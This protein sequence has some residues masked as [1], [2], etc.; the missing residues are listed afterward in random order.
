MGGVI[1]VDTWLRPWFIAIGVFLAEHVVKVAGWARDGLDIPAI[2]DHRVRDTARNEYRGRRDRNELK[3]TP[4][5]Q[6]IHGSSS[7]TSLVLATSVAYGMSGFDL[8]ER[9][10]V[11]SSA[12]DSRNA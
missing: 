8:A 10:V 5:R 4:A 7:R 9:R 6:P 3:A 12:G 2:R 1:I 11:R